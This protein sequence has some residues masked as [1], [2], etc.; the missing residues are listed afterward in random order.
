MT[1]VVK[2]ADP[3]SRSVTF[4]RQR[5]R[6]GKIVR[7]HEMGMFNGKDPGRK[8]KAFSAGFFRDRLGPTKTRHAASVAQY[9][10]VPI[11][12]RCPKVDTE[13][14]FFFFTQIAFHELMFIHN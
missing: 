8:Q 10:F 13:N 1:C 11:N 5:P 14:N 2:R 3:S 7:R 4:A 6:S 12:A 9:R